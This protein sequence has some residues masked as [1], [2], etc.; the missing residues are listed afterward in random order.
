MGYVSLIPADWHG[1]AED[2]RLMLGKQGCPLP[3]H[4]NA[5]GALVRSARIKGLL[6]EIGFE[7]AK[8]KKSHARRVLTYRRT[9]KA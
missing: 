8:T 1:T 4:H 7:K 9:W 3:H 2:M 6:S 5:W